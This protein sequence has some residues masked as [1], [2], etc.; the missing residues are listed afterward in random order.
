MLQKPSKYEAG[1]QKCSKNLASTRLEAPP[2]WGDHTIGGGG[3]SPG[4][5]LIYIYTYTH[6]YSDYHMYFYILLSFAWET[7]DVHVQAEAYG[8]LDF[9]LEA[10]AIPRREKRH[11]KRK[12]VG[13]RKWLLFRLVI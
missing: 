2:Q 11:G 3:G 13:K 5:G 7:P 8:A 10:K 12:G 9:R 4:T 6:R 1:S